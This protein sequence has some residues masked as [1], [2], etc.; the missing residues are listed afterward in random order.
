MHTRNS[1]YNYLLKSIATAVK[2]WPAFLTLI[3]YK[4]YASALIFGR[5]LHVTTPAG[6]HVISHNNLG[7]Y[8]LFRI[9]F[10]C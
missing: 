6:Y 4:I 10:C 9:I 8:F 1:V 3:G 2:Y 5:K 7:S